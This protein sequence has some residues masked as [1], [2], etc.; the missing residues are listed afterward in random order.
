MRNLPCKHV[1]VDEV[2]A[3]CYAKQKNVVTARKAV[4]GAGDIWTGTAICA[5]TKLIPSWAVGNRD[6]ET[7]KPFI[8]DLASRLKNKIQLT[9]DGLK[10]YIEACK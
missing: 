6:A 10:A 8:E 4:E 1:Q 9:S 7:A 3:F 2:W 5:D